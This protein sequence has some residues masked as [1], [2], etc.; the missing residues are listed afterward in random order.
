MNSIWFLLAHFPIAVNS[1]IQ[2]NNVVLKSHA[3]V[4]KKQP[5]R[6]SR[7]INIRLNESRSSLQDRRFPTPLSMPIDQLRQKLNGQGRALT[8]WDCYKIG[9]DPLYF[10]SG[11]DSALSDIWDQNVLQVIKH[12]PFNYDTEVKTEKHE[13]A[14]NDQS[15][16]LTNP[17]FTDRNDI[18]EKYM[19]MKRRD[20][21]SK[22]EGKGMGHKALNQLSDLYPN[23][24]GLEYSVA[25]LVNVQRSNDGTVKLLLKLNSKRQ[26]KHSDSSDDNSE[27]QHYYIESVII[28]WYDRSQPTSTLC[29][30]SQVGCAQG[31]T[32]CATVSNLESMFNDALIFYKHMFNNQTKSLFKIY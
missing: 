32:F 14:H 16:L 28:P 7:K 23:T 19:P 18:V 17:F 8:T 26:S 3:V 15:S 31:C 22:S 20:I 21:H 29:M 25:S 27:N 4:N 30:S 5:I 13:K 6:T 9:I 24:L 10:F 1:F 2:F 11:D 12:T